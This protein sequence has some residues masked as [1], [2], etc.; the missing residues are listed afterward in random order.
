MGEEYEKALFEHR[1]EV[2]ARLEAMKE[3]HKKDRKEIRTLNAEVRNLRD[4]NERL[5]EKL[6]QVEEENRVL[7]AENAALRKESQLLR[8][9]NERMKRILNNDSSNTSLPPSTDRPGKAANR[10]NGRQKTGKKAGGQPGHPGKHISKA[11]VEQKIREGVYEHRVEEI[12]A[13]GKEYVTRYRLDLEIRVIATEIRIYADENGKYHIPD[14]MKA[15][16]F[17]GETIQAIAGHL[18]SE[19]VMANDR[20]CDFINSLSGDTLRISTGSVYGFCKGFAEKCAESCEVIEETLLNEETICTDATPVKT[21]G[22]QTYI[23]NF[24]TEES[25][26]YVSA[27]K[28]DL[29][30]M[31]KMEIL[32]RFTGTLVHDHETAMYRFGTRH[33]ECNVHLLRY[34]KKNTEETA[35]TWSRDMS[36][37]LHGLNCARK[38]AIEN[39]GTEFLQEQLERFDQRYDEIVALGREQNKHTRGKIAKKEECAL[40]NRLEKYKINYLLFLHD[41]TIPFSNNMSERDLRICKN[42][43]KMAGGFRTADGRQMYCAI[44]SFVQTVKRRGLNILHSISSLMRGTPVFT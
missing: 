8:A 39:G 4:E 18:Y 14:Q 30:T 10:Y 26:L 37:F 7:R 40:L 41:F 23:R 38:E 31:N 21:N 5:R 43:Q 34:L 2:E 28:K 42:R 25:V 12:G 32:K 20:I 1:K 19:G 9:E 17:Y 35:N 3:E 22:K 16:V 33:G 29:K 36:G 27:E 11:E 44:M 24:S 15:E 6:T 13:P